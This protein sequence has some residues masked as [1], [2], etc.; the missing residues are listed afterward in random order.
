MNFLHVILLSLIE[1]VTEFLP[2]SSTAHLGIVSHILGIVQTDF[3]K[4]FEIGIQFG[5]I[6]AVVVVYYKKI[7]TSRAV[8]S[9][10]IVGFIPTGIIGFILYHV[11][12]KFLIG[13]NWV[14]SIALLVGGFLMLLIERKTSSLSPDSTLTVVGIESLS[15]IDMIKIG[16]IQSFA[17]IPGVSRSGAII[18]GGMFM[19]ISRTVIVET[20]FLLA[21]PTMAAAVGYDLL[22]TG[23]RFSTHEWSMMF[24]GFVITFLISL[25]VVHWLL[26]YIRTKTFQVFAW[27]RI[28]I[29]VL[30]LI[31][32]LIQR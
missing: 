8:L 27:Y 1:G 7:I 20:A 15:Y 28:I 24:L 32:L 25:V 30:L 6:L 9:R 16:I 21:I 4:S 18:V 12:K 2:I 3:V 22:K 31:F 26:R 29:G 17:V 11:V 19:N 23:S 5:A 13:N 14:A 10:I